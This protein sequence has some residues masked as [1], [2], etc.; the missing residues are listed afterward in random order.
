MEEWK[1]I[2]GY[3]GIYQISN[4]GNVKSLKYHKEKRIKSNKNR[5]GYLKIGLILNGKRKHISIHRLVAKAFI[6]NPNSLPEVNH[7]D[8]NKENNKVENLEW[9]NRKQ[10]SLHAYKTGLRQV[11]EKQKEASRK[12]IKIAQSCRITRHTKFKEV[13]NERITR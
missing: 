13:E 11:T 9:N 5:N 7:I 6:P 1:D 12:N 2:E 10:N 4:L 8:G 3:E